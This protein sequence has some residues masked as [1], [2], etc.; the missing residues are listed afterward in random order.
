MMPKKYCMNFFGI[1]ITR[2]KSWIDRY[3]VNH[4]LIHTRQMRELLYVPFYLLYVL[5]WLVKLAIYRNREQAYV[6]ISFEREAYAYGHDLDY[7]P[8]RRRYAW[9][10]FL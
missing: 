7:L 10:R 9:L 1:I 4:E 8:R 3:V 5:E 6:N 2:D